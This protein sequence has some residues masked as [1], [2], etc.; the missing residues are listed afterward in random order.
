MNFPRSMHLWRLRSQCVRRVASFADPPEPMQAHGWAGILMYHR[1]VEQL[2][3]TQFPTWNVTPEKF[4]EQLSG[5]VASGFRAIGLRELVERIQRGRSIPHR[6][7][8]VTFDDG[9]ENVYLE[10]WP[11]L[12]RLRIPA[13]IFLATR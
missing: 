4:A 2:Q 11:I 5:L 8:V 12:K 6:T 1:V 10:A 3:G 7:F 13:T 9:Y